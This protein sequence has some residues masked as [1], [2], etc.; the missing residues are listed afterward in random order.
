[1]TKQL[2]PSHVTP[3]VTTQMPPPMACILPCLTYSL[4]TL[5]KQELM[6]PP[7]TECTIT[8]AS[9]R[10]PLLVLTVAIRVSSCHLGDGKTEARSL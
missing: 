9:H 3:F 5:C 4:G 2:C 6:M 8:P 1:M 10:L 7:G